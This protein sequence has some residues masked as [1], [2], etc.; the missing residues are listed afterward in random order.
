[1][2]AHCVRLCGFVNGTTFSSRE[3]R[4]QQLAAA[5]ARISR[6]DCTNYTGNEFMSFEQRQNA[7][8]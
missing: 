3:Q 8:M 1:V 5:A 7:Q 6:N 4:L 2:R